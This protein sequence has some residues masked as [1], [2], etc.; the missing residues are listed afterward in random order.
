MALAF[1]DQT[2]TAQKTQLE[3]Y[4][5]VDGDNSLRIVGDIL[6]RY[7]Y[8]VDGE[9][10]KKLP[11][12]CL[13]F[14]RDTETFD[15]A[16]KDWIQEY[17]PDLRCSW[18]YV[19]QCIEDGQIKIVNLK[20]KLWEQ[21]CMAAE[22]LGDPTDPD[23]GWDIKFRRQKTGPNVYNIEYTLRPLACKKRPLNDEERALLDDLK[24]MDEVMQRPTPE[25]QKELL[26]RIRGAVVVEETDDEALEA[27]FKVD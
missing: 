9:N 10:N 21:I 11:L 6:A 23:E 25:K 19:T 8:W 14:N 12:E 7:V 18:S 26:D 20:K 3:A 17:Y 5:Y 16:D 1:K 24:S 4:K 15:N 27:E 2:G 13:S 22:D